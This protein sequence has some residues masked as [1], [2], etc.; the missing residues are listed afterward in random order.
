LY[1]GLTNIPTPVEALTRDCKNSSPYFVL[2][3]FRSPSSRVL[4]WISVEIFALICPAKSLRTWD[5]NVTPYPHFRNSLQA[6][7][8]CTK[9]SPEPPN[10]G[11]ILWI[12]SKTRRVLSVGCSF[13]SDLN[14]SRMIFEINMSMSFG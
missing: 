8:I 7:S 11:R 5:I 4:I 12:S 9:P 1:A 10:F 3:L 2:I 14:I 13:G 6:L